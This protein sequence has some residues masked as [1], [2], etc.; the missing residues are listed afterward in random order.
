MQIKTFTIP[1][2]GGEEQNEIMNKFLRG[3]KVVDFE[4]HL[5]SVH[6]VYYWAF[7]VRYLNNLSS[8]VS[9]ERHEKV[10]YKNVLD[11]DAFQRFSLMRSIRKRMAKMDAVPAY[12]IFTDAEMSEAAKIE[13]LTP[14]A[15]LQVNG[16]GKKKVE[17]YG[18]IFCQLFA[19]NQPED[20]SL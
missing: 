7:C 15:L 12:A 14:Q 13:K 8:F 17:K 3:N 18:E 5:I 10:D 2:M 6:E 16:I 19:E 1:L 11:A 20:S 9:S 4:Q